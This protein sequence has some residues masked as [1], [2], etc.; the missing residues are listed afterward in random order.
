MAAASDQSPF[1][2]QAVNI[3]LFTIYVYASWQHHGSIARARRCRRQIKSQP[4]ESYGSWRVSTQ[5]VPSGICI[6]ATSRKWP[7]GSLSRPSS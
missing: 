3:A 5:P 2:I 1:M 7:G 4:F 6:C